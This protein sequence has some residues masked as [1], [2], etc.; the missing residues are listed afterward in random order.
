MLGVDPAPDAGRLL[1]TVAPGPTARRA[2]L[3]G[4][5]ERLDRAAGRLRA[6]VAEAVVR[7]RAP[8]LAFTVTPDA[9]GE[10]TP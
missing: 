2:G 10:V 9:A 7:K 8:E 1:A 5:L 4:I 6:E 3:G